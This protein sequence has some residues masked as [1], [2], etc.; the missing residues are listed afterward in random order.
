MVESINRYSSQEILEIFKE[1]HR[2]YS[3]IDLE[4]DA[5]AE[6]AADMSIRK[7][8][9]ANDLLG[10]KELSM[11]LNQEFR[12][13]VD[14]SIWQQTLE[15]SKRRK[16]IDVCELIARHATKEY[17]QPKIIFGQNCLKASVF[18]TIKNNLKAKKVDVSEL[19]PSSNL[20]FYINKY[21]SPVMEE[22]TLTGT[23]TI[24]KLSTVSAK[25]EFSKTIN[26]YEDYIDVIY[27]E[28][29]E[30]FR[31]LVSKIIDERNQK[32]LKPLSQ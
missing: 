25:K 6:I 7:W 19:R 17:F 15:P 3:P 12:I 30:T 10:W 20:S 32:I 11:F 18:L 14:E 4:A 24:G 16:L 31:D 5:S 22:I 2:L 28:N 8:R 13:D 23:K 1:Q 21:F 9:S 27:V 26:I 29:T